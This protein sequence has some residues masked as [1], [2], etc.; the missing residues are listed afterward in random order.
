[1]L[2][3][4]AA[5]H[6]GITKTDWLESFHTFSFGHYYDPEHMGFGDLRVIN[7]DKVIAGA[8]FGTHGHKNMEILTYVIRGSLAHKDSTG[9]G[10]VIQAGDVQRLSA[11]AGITHSEFNHSKDHEVH[12]LQIWCLPASENISPSYEQKTFPTEQKHNQFCLLASQNGEAGSI[13][14]HQDINMFAAM[15]EEGQDLGYTITRNRR[16]WVHIAEGQVN[17]NQHQLGTGD[18]VAVTNETKLEFS[19]AQGAHIILFDLS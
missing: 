19:D 1:M 12:F 2:K 3:I 17:L 11:G 14:L 5:N 16:C 7:D 15:L 10:S 18:G 4:R 9:N 6:R 8:G 13:S